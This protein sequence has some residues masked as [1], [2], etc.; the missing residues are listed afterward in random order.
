M[1]NEVD[2]YFSELII[3]HI[4]I[5]IT[6]SVLILEV[7]SK[8]LKFGPARQIDPGSGRSGAGTRSD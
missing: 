5:F 1:W 3:L 4:F 7:A 8:V 6:S 2:Y